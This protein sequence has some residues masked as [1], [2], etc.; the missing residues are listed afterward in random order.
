MSPSHPP[1]SLHENGCH[2]LWVTA[3]PEEMC[4]T[5]LAYSRNGLRGRKRG[6]RVGGLGFHASYNRFLCWIG[7]DGV[8]WQKVSCV[9]AAERL[10]DIY[11]FT[12]IVRMK[13]N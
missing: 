4:G 2:G 3:A 10:S 7:E 1:R 9:L 13:E 6:D 5:I 11:G 8:K 12:A